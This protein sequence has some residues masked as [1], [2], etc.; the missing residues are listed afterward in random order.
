MS[1]LPGSVLQALVYTDDCDLV[2]W[3]LE[4]LG[5]PKA[6]GSGLLGGYLTLLWSWQGFLDLVDL[7][8]PG[9]L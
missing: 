9:K 7:L 3:S 2:S 6:A 5:S 8:I 4:A 1:D